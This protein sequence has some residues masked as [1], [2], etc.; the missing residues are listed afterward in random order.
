MQL[1]IKNLK[2][3]YKDDCIIDNISYVLDKGVYGLLG[4]DGAGKTTFLRM[5][6]TIIQPTS[7]SITWNNE[8]IFEL[9]AEYRKVLGYLP[10]DF[11]FYPD[12]SVYDYLMYISSM[13]GLFP[14]LAKKRIKYLLTELLLINIKDKK[15]K[16]L[17]KESLKVVGIAQAMLNNPK[18]LILDEP[19]TGLD[20]D[21]KNKFKRMIN[22]LSEGRIVLLSSNIISDISFI[23][24][25][26]L[27]LNNGD[28]A[29]TE[30]RH[31]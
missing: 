14:N 9:G 17:S 10:Q 15:M 30:V 12:I 22:R 28:F 25:K 2:K 1:K 18:I 4:D 8:D 27:L 23:A 5:I 26:I 20:L 21:E 6:C 3:Y 24:N 29:I 19:L 13:K 7:G 16:D 11:G 31:K